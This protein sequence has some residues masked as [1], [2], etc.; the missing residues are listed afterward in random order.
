MDRE[1]VIKDLE[2]CLSASCRG[3]RPR[4]SCPYNDDEWDI[5]RDALALLKE[6]KPK[7]ESK[8]MLPCKCGCKR[9]EHWYSA[10]PERPEELRCIKC[11]FSVVG[12]DATDVIRQWNKAVKDCT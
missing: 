1:R 5:M 3:F 10:N 9:R 6:Q 8:A 4:Q 11:G 7:R 2:E 12:R